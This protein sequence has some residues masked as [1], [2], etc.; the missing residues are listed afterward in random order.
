MIERV[1]KLLIVID[2]GHGG[3]CRANRGP[4]GYVEADGVLDIALRLYDMLV[5]AGYKVY[6][7][8]DTDTTVSLQ[9]RADLANNLSADLFISLHTNAGP[10][11]ARG[12]ETFYTHD[13]AEAKRVAG[14]IQQSLVDGTGWTNRGI[15]TRLIDNPKSPIFRKDYYA[16]IR[17]TNMPA[18]ILETGFHTN[19][20]E[21]ALL[22]QEGIRQLIAKAILKGIKQAY[23]LEHT[24]TPTN[25]VI[26]RE[27]KINLHGKALKIDGFFH[28]DRNYVPIAFLRQLGYSVGWDG[29]SVLIDY[30][31]EG[32]LW[33]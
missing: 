19:F 29:E 30:N 5:I 33:K 17:N 20:I 25:Q 13:S 26:E 4:T 14:I 24:Y 15:K 9:Q 3:K 31:K 8:R 7:T 12:I 22:K 2:A 27:I 23:P 10:E 21:E 18:L 28:N 1:I 6:L 11:A 32:E 16:V